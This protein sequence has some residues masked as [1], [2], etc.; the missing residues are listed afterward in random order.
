MAREPWELSF[1]AEPRDL[2]GLRRIV[3]LHLK[4]W[5]LS[6]Q[7]PAAELCV[8][9]LVTHVIRHVGAGA[10]T[11]LRLSMNGTYLRIEVRDPGR[12]APQLTAAEPDTEEGRG[13][14]LVDA[15][16][17]R[18]GVLV[19]ADHKVTWC[20]VATDLTASDGH[21]GSVYVTRA[22]AVIFLYEAVASP[23]ATTASWSRPATAVAK[24]AAMEVIVDLLHW[25]SAHGYDV[26]DVLDVAHLRFVAAS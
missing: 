23:R 15:M 13:L 7:C 12:H 20:E 9:E 5:G 25:V 2:A 26:D 14:A 6:R 17:A 8:S 11:S 10:P 16:A 18:F 1:L 24:D 4:G 22:E 3:R 19:V 21:R